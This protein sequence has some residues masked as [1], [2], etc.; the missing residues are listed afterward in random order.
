MDHSLVVVKGHGQLNEALSH[1]M[2]GH[3]ARR[4]NLSILKEVNPECSLEE[5]MLKL[6]LQYLGHLMWR[7]ISLEKTLML[8]KMEGKEGGGR[9][10][11]G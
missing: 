1:A 9:E 10:W 3:P 11:D 8:G 4:W 6:K 7:A 5:L 2:Q